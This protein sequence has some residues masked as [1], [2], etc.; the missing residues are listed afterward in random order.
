MK[1]PNCHTE[2]KPGSLYC[3]KCLTEIPWVQEFSSVETLLEKKKREA[4]EN[5][6]LQDKRTRKQRWILS[7][8]TGVVLCALAAIVIVLLCYRQLHTFSALYMRADKAF[9]KEKYDSALGYTEMALEKEPDNLSAN[10][11]LAKILEKQGDTKSAVMVLQPMIKLYAD[12]ETLYKTMVRYL[13]AEGRPGEIKK[14]LN[15]CE[16]QKVLE[17]CS[18]YVCMEPVSS[19]PPGTYTSVRTVELSAEYDRI[20]YTLDGTMPTQQSM[21]YDSPII[22]PE[23][24]TE[25]N[26]FGINNKNIPSDIITRKYV[27][28]LNSPEPPEITP[29]SGNYTENTKIEVKVPDGCRAYYAFDQIPTASSTEYER[30]ISMP[31]GSHVF[32]AIL[33]AANGKVSETSSREFYLEY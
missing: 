13:S 8:R 1:C 22:L 11:L 4:P 16:S 7:R 32:N 20:Y 2:V 3:P 30:P 21:K 5:L 10:L 17:A 27:I 31:Q 23:G 19:L 28:V 6:P 25:L 18:E 26:A 33:V 9:A 12:S 29:E 14:I 24:T 15:S